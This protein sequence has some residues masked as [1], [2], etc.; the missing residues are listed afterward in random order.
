MGRRATRILAAA[1]FAV[2]LVA[3]LAPEAGG[4]PVVTRRGFTC[5]IVGTPMGEPLHGTP[6]R[7]VI[8]GL[9]GNDDSGDSAATTC[10][11]AATAVTS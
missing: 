2:L 6:G 9:G 1:L 5:T 8:C 4:S 3:L 7:D 11:W 10:C